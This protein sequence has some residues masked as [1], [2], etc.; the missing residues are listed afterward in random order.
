VGHQ[1][2]SA[3]LG[4][5]DRARHGPLQEAALELGDGAYENDLVLFEHDP[6]LGERDDNPPWPGTQTRLEVAERPAS[7]EA[8][9]PSRE[10][11]PGG[12]S[13]RDV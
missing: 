3:A 11:W 2:P 1:P 9:H 10:L 6:L 7:F 13:S 4:Q 5:A 8:E 12:D